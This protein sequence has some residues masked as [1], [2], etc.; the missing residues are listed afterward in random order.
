V[1]WALHN[2]PIGDCWSIDEII[3]VKNYLLKF[4]FNNEVV[5]S[6]NI[7]EDIKLGLTS[8]KKY[9]ENYKKTIKNLSKVGVKIICYNFMPVFDW[10]RTDLYKSLPDKSTALFYEKSKIENINPFEFLDNMLKQKGLLSMPGWEQEKLSKI[11]KLFK[12]YDGF[13]VDNL[14]E[15]AKYFLNE[16][17][18]VCE[19]VNIKMAIHPDDPPW[20]I[21]GLPRLITSKENIMRYLNLVN[22]NCNGI[23]LCTGSLGSSKKN[24]IVDIIKTFKNKIFFAHIRNI[25]R[26]DNG[27]FIECSHRSCDGSLDIVDIVRTFY[28][29]DFKYYIRPDHGRHIWNEEKRIGLRPGYGLYD[30]ALGIMYILGIFDTMCKI[31]N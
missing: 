21:F 7:H 12:Q 3:N 29:I 13:T 14:F 4:G 20:S 28:D 27:D 5:E 17:I 2:T 19:E 11:K 6:V 24:N 1:V 18:P 26:F 30:R 23:T 22:S 9:I 16:I 25:K 10:T 15:N 8:R 31:K